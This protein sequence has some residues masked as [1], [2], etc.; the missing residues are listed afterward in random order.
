[1]RADAGVSTEGRRKRNNGA[2]ATRK[3]V[4]V[5]VRASTN[6]QAR[7]SS[8]RIGV[9]VE[10]VGFEATVFEVEEEDKEEGFGGDC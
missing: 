9:R 4:D 3:R 1:M 2:S 5:E 8:G 7:R 10:V 6:S